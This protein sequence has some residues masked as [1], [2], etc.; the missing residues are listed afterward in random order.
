VIIA[1]DLDDILYDEITFVKS[2]LR[3]VSDYLMKSYSIPIE[4]STDFLE[5]RLLKGRNK[6]LDDLLIN[7]R[8]YSK[9]EVRKCLS[10]YRT[11][12]PNIQLYPEAN[13]VLNRFKDFS[14]YV[15]TDGN[16]IVQKNK[17]LALGLF[18]KVK[19]CILTS[20]YGLKN[21]KP[22]PYCFLRICKKEKIKPSEFIYVGDNPNKDFVGLKPL[23]FKTIRVLKG[24]YRNIKKDEEYEAQYTINSLYE[25]TPELI[26]NIVER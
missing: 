16:R 25:L 4:D 22:S 14:L 3:A 15:I 2:G 17:M 18:D 10:I 8:L 9:M 12:Y 1:F 19:S 24:Q 21:S 26:R 20:Y 6:I 7:F 23:G 11:H 13:L 5:H